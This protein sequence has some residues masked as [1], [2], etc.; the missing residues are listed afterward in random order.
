MPPSHP[1]TFLFDLLEWA[2]L[3][4]GPTGN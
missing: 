1:F 3:C 2:R 4:G